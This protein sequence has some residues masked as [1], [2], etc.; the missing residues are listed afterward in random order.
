V[1]PPPLVISDAEMA[2]DPRVVDKVLSELES[3]Q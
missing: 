1:P 3:P 2:E